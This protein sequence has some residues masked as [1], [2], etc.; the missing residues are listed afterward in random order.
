MNNAKV[1][2]ADGHIIERRD[3]LRLYLKP[4]IDSARRS[5]GR[6]DV[7]GHCESRLSRR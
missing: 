1:I 7:Y 2:D 4:P 3:E 6:F 5:A